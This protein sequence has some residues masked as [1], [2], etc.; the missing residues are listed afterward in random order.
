[1]TIQLSSYAFK[2][3]PG[4]ILKTNEDLVEVN[5]VNNIFMIFDGFGGVGIGDLAVNYVREKVLDFYTSACSDP[6]ST[7]PYFYDPKYKIELN[8]LMNGIYHVHKEFMKDNMSRQAG[9]RAG[10]SFI[11][12]LYVDN[13]F[14]TVSVGNC[15]CFARKK[16]KLTRIT[17]PDTLE[18]SNLH[19]SDIALNLYPSN[20]FG[21]YN[22]PQFN[23][24]EFKINPGDQIILCTDGIYAYLSNEEINY[25]LSKNFL[26]NSQR[27]QEILDLS[28]LRGNWDNQSF[29]LL[30]F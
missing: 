8:V 16:E 17:K 1:M 23:I 7:L 13:L 14:M 15:L 3:S 9:V 5:L 12:G 22:K 26:T 19:G 25:I 4:P 18:D 30:N 21:L 20:A 27:V 24:S 28:N 6:D 2:S 10:M 29:I 11:I